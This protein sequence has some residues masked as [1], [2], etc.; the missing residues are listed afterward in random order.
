MFIFFV[1]L[2]VYLGGI[3]HGWFQQPRLLFPMNRLSLTFHK[4]SPTFALKSADPNKKYRINIIS[5]KLIVPKVHVPN[6]IT[7]NIEKKLSQTPAGG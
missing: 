2:F 7:L 5:A 1:C 4:A 3:F 6:E